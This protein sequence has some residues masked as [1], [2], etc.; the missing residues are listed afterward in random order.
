MAKGSIAKENITKKIAEA[1]GSDY[2]GESDKKLYVWGD[3]N[4]EK[5]QIAISMTCPKILFNG[6]SDQTGFNSSTSN[7]EMNFDTMTEDLPKKA[8][9]SVDEK[10]NIEN[11]MAKLGL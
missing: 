6:D 3:E 7:G 5:I 10:K 4:G 8:E 9:I 11:L 1:F 2:I